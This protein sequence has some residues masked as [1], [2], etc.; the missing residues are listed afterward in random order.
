MEIDYPL[1]SLCIH[2]IQSHFAAKQSCSLFTRLNVHHFVTVVEIRILEVWVY[3]SW[4]FLE[5]VNLF[6]L[7]EREAVSPQDGSRA[8]KLQDF[9]ANKESTQP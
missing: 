3:H 1:G 4:S 2:S 5:A 9:K 7:R 6:Q 8:R